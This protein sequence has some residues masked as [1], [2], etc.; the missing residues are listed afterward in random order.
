MGGEGREGREG[1]ERGMKEGRR[2]DDIHSIELQALNL[3]C[4]MFFG[5]SQR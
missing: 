2:G 4:V 5:N 1:R 3:F